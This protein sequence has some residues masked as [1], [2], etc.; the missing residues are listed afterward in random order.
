MLHLVGQAPPSNIYCSSADLLYHAVT[1]QCVIYSG[2]D[3]GE[4][5]KHCMFTVYNDTLLVMN[6]YD[7]EIHSK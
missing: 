2:P 6:Y 1:Q 3:C 5:L 7:I 4:I